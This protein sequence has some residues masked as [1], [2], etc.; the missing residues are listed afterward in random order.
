MLVVIAIMSMMAFSNNNWMN[1]I[2]DPNRLRWAGITLPAMTVVT[3]SMGISAV[4]GNNDDARN[5]GERRSSQ[6]CKKISRTIHFVLQSIVCRQLP[7]VISLQKFLLPESPCRSR[8]NAA[9]E[10][11]P[12]RGTTLHRG[13]STMSFRTWRILDAE[14]AAGLDGGDNNLDHAEPLQSTRR[15]FTPQMYRT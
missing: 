10:S 13:N 2:N 14:A 15:S 11:E 7:A 9:R 6:H 4:G 8:A 12:S 3:A 5:A 1:R